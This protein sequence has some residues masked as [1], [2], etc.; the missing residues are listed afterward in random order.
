MTEFACQQ[1]FTCNNHLIC[2]YTQYY[3]VLC[4]RRR[5]S[6]VNFIEHYTAEC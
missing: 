2:L 4:R 5:M 3:V 6:Y 1:S